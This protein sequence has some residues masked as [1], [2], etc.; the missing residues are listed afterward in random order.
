MIDHQTSQSSTAVRGGVDDWGDDCQLQSGAGAATELSFKDK[1]SV[2]YCVRA[3][4]TVIADPLVLKRKL[5]SMA[6]AR[7]TPPESAPLTPA[8]QTAAHAEW[9]LNLKP[10]ERVRVKSLQEIKA[11]LDEDN[12]CER[13]AYLPATMNK[14]CGGTYTVRKRIGR[15]FD[16]RE[17]R[18]MKLKNVVIL[19]GVHC[20]PPLNAEG[21]PAGCDRTC[22]LFWKEAWLE[23]A[24]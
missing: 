24:E 10:G 8:P 2:R 22:F 12:R 1:L 15:F 20:E 11:T 4:K 21:G 19:D 13:M 6:A 14:F 5:E 16:E 3:I 7:R 9:I 18:L 23:R 17:W